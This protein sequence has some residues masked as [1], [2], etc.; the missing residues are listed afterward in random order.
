[1]GY[2]CICSFKPTFSNI[3]SASFCASALLNPLTLIGATIQ[4]FKIVICGN[5]LKCWKTM[6]ISLRT[7]R[8][9]FSLARAIL[10]FFS[11]FHKFVPSTIIS[12]EV[13]SSRVI[14]IRIIVVLPDPDGPDRKS[15]RLNSSHVSISYAVFC[16]KTAIS[17]YENFHLSLHD[18]L[19]IF[20]KPCQYHYELGADVFHWHA[21]FF[22]SFPFSINSF[23]QR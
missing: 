18:A 3:S 15:T 2:L 6:P 19:P 21:P 5:R 16:L 17:T 23:R 9:C 12:P 14:N 7:W 20:G 8:R 10:P 22:R 13:G 11:I 1:L 4:F